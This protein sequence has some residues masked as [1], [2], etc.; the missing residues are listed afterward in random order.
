MMTHKTQMQMALQR[1]MNN[2]TL[3]QM[4]AS[5]G[6]V[7]T[8]V[9]AGIEHSGLLAEGIAVRGGKQSHSSNVG[10]SS[11]GGVLNNNKRLQV[12][13]PAKDSEYAVRK[14][15]S[16]PDRNRGHEQGEISGSAFSSPV[17]T[18]TATYSPLLPSSGFSSPLVSH[19]YSAAKS[20]NT[21]LSSG[22]RTASTP[23]SSTSG[24]AGLNF[25]DYCV[26]GGER[27]RYR[28]HNQEGF[29]SML[30]IDADNACGSGSC[31]SFS[32]PRIHL[33][34]VAN[35]QGTDRELG[36]QKCACVPRKV[37]MVDTDVPLSFVE[38]VCYTWMLGSEC[39][40]VFVC[41]CVCVCVCVW[42]AVPTSESCSPH[43]RLC[44]SRAS[45]GPMWTNEDLTMLDLVY[46]NGNGTTPSSGGNT[47]TKSRDALMVVG[48]GEMM[49]SS[50]PGVTT[51]TAAKKKL[52][53][54]DDED[55]RLGDDHERI[56]GP[57][58]NNHGGNNDNS[59]DSGVHMTVQAM[60][61]LHLPTTA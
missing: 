5:H 36:L 25:N 60:K 16:T 31:V 56:S 4:H 1:K 57:E 43:V 3:K 8:T 38:N 33:I 39:T 55:Q 58:C 54:G 49:G 32:L 10:V 18:T 2:L 46:N 35:T 30:M 48:S 7:G 47:G 11:G 27:N 41:V 13:L 28:S 17:S 9:G 59:V 29:D 15:M 34:N 50:K 44:G 22:S 19:K 12:V 42:T 61:T 40:N 53:V 14:G 21:N 37:H 20:P 51:K 24:S 52:L 45:C 23:P 26:V 6:S